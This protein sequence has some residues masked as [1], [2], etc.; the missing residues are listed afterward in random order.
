MASLSGPTKPRTQP[1]NCG[2]VFLTLIPT[3]GFGVV[4]SAPIMCMNPS[5]YMIFID[6]TIFPLTKIDAIAATKQRLHGV[7]SIV[8]ED[9]V[10]M[11][12]NNW[13][14]TPVYVPFF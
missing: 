12:H 4:K 9:L 5:C 14:E 7:S 2:W 10:Y 6:G 13:C 11:V 3:L 1:L 8:I